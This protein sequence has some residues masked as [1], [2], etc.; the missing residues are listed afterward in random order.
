MADY[1]ATLKE[2]LKLAASE[3]WER[4]QFG[5]GVGKDQKIYYFNTKEIVGNKYGTLTPIPFKVLVDPASG[6]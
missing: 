1:K 4:F 2:S 5:G 3:A 6:R